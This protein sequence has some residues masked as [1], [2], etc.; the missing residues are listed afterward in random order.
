MASSTTAV[1]T[2]WRCP[3]HLPPVA[4][5]DEGAFVALSGDN[6]LVPAAPAPEPS[7]LML[8]AGFST[9]STG[10]FYVP[11]DMQ[12]FGVEGAVFTGAQQIDQV[13]RAACTARD[14]ASFRAAW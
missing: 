1:W 9:V 12:Q 2:T 6:A 7:A 3:S 5:G 10:A 14:A 4:Q 11:V 13:D 8:S